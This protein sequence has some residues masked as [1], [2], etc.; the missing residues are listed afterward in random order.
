[1]GSR[2]KDPTESEVKV[3]T[4][5]ASLSGHHQSGRELEMSQECLQEMNPTVNEL[6]AKDNT[7]W[8]TGPCRREGHPG[9]YHL[10]ALEPHRL[11]AR[12]SQQLLNPFRRRCQ[13]RHIIWKIVL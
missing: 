6:M 7:P 8:E 11:E 4:L 13:V 12:L 10:A 5:L 9:A 1:M 2:D 3:L